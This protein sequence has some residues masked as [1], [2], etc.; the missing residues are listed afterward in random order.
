MSIVA[1]K[2]KS[3]VKYGSNIS[4]KPPGGTWL[5]QGPFGKH[6]LT[7]TQAINNPN[8]NGF[9]INGG[10]RNTG[11]VGKSYMMSKSG[12]PFRGMNPIGWGG[13]INQYVQ[14]QPTFNVNEVYTKG[15][16]YKYIKPSV[17]STFG[18]LSKKYRWI[19]GQYPNVW[20]Q[21]NY[22]G[23]QT[24][25]KSQGTYISDKTSSNMCVSDVNNVEKYENYIVSCGPTLCQTSTANFT[26]NNMASNAPYT[27]YLNQPVDSSQYLLGLQRKCT[28]PKGPQKPFPYATNGDPCFS[29][30]IYL[31]PPSWYTKTP[32][33]MN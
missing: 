17:L 16:Q 6:T 9:S 27:K 12:T 8:N 24:D 18:M 32:S 29:N 2:K 28:D 26:F 4:G 11:Y 23:N 25:S 14:A 33:G 10:T 5:P 19:R 22:T 13:H 21:P 31:S 1:F 3:V 15:D 20:V 7:L 30:V